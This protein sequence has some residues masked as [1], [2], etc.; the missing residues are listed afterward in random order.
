MENA[1][2]RAFVLGAFAALALAAGA[3]AAVLDGTIS[4][5][6]PIVG[7]TSGFELLA[8]PVS[9]FGTPRPLGGQVTVTPLGFGSQPITAWSSM[10]AGTMF[11]TKTFCAASSAKV[12]LAAP[13]LPAAGVYPRSRS[14]GSSTTEAVLAPHLDVKCLF[15]A[16][17]LIHVRAVL[18]RGRPVSAVVAV[19][20]AVGRRELIAYV[21]WSPAIVRAR[22][23]TDCAPN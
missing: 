6:L 23:S 9:G 22:A 16:R 14:G 2:V 18:Q 3:H 17:V 11:D 8:A 20:R 12:A 4:C 1:G 7:G 13:K 19:A 15:A 5:H 21:E 10:Y